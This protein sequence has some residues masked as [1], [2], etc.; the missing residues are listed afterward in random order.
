MWQ[1]FVASCQ[2]KENLVNI[3][4]AVRVRVVVVGEP[5][6]PRAGLGLDCRLGFNAKTTTTT[7]FYANAA[8]SCNRLQRGLA[9]VCATVCIVATVCVCVCVCAT[10]G[11]CVCVCADSKV[12]RMTNHFA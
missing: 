9:T 1:Q 12:N 3:V 6:T 2:V 8:H 10:A 4:N 7:T 11:M 5:P